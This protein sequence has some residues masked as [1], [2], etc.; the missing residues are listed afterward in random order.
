MAFKLNPPDDAF[1]ISIKTSHT[2]S[3]NKMIHP[4]M[5][6]V[7]CFNITEFVSLA[8]SVNHYGILIYLHPPYLASHE[9]KIK[10]V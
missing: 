6:C 1:C 9:N 7:V 8:G 5:L 10:Q 4:S 3:K 2:T